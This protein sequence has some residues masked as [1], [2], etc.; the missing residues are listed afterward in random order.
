MMWKRCRRPILNPRM[1]PQGL[2]TPAFTNQPVE[3]M[4]AHGKAIE[5]ASPHLPPP[6]HDPQWGPAPGRI[7]APAG[8]WRRVAAFIIDGM[9]VGIPSRLLSNVIPNLALSILVPILA[10]GAYFVICWVRM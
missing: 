1:R 9:I 6:S 2:Q 3:R 4:D 5:S 8:F 7:G 10:V